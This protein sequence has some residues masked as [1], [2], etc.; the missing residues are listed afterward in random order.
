MGARPLQKRPIC[1]L[2]P[3]LADAAG[4]AGPIVSS[5]GDAFRIPANSGQKFGRTPVRRDTGRT[6]ARVS[7]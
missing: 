4:H 6:D 2:F 5:G 7:G 3:A 1:G